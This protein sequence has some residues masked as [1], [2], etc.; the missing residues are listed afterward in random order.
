MPLNFYPTAKMIQ[1]GLLI[2]WVL[3]SK[4]IIGLS[5]NYTNFKIIS[6]YF[7][8]KLNMQ[9]KNVVKY[10]LAKYNFKLSSPDTHISLESFFKKIE[11]TNIRT[12]LIYN[13]PPVI[14]LK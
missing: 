10:F 13:S 5:K 7:I 6:S 2:I 12:N 14:N 3:K 9:I 1:V 11:S 4:V 8:D